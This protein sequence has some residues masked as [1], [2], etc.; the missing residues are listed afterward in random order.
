MPQDKDSSVKSA[1]DEIL[2]IEDDR[3]TRE[4]AERRRREEEERRSREENERRTREEEE[5]RKREEE[6]RR[7]DEERRLRDE[8]S[9][10]LHLRQLEEMRV[11]QETEA[12]SRLMEEEIRLKHEKDLAVI[13]AQK[14]SV[15]I[16]VWIVIA[17][18]VLG[19]GTAG[20]LVYLDRQ[21]K[22]EEAD[23][24]A[25]EKTES[26]RK[27]QEEKAEA[28]RLLDEERR[29][30]Q[31][32]LAANRAA[33]AEADRKINELMEQIASGR[34]TDAQMAAL[35]AELQQAQQDKA[36]LV[37][38][39]AEAANTKKTG[40]RTSGGRTSGGTGTPVTRTRKCLHQGTPME[41][42]FMCPGDPRC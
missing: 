10:K 30:F 31:Q 17:V 8:E 21:E 3:R 1:L 7:I 34:V 38:A 13:D 28:A 23:R 26:D 16:W 19:G 35:R 2:G 37:D 20:T 29:M 24:L 36:S 25:K 14:K 22:Q 9:R 15:P 11:K 41:E 32:E 6:Q 18:V 40:G 39:A 33:Q 5:R 12:R 42:C 4:E 27:A